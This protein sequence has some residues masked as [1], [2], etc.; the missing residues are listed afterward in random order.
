M[1]KN[2]FFMFNQTDTPEVTELRINGVIGSTWWDDVVEQE[3]INK[4]DSV[5]SKK[6]IVK[7]NSMGGEVFAGFSIYNSLRGHKADIE[8]IVEGMA[9]SVAS[10]IAMAGDTIKMSKTAAI[11]IHNPWTSGARGESKD[12]RSRADALDKMKEMAL[13]AYLTKAKI[14]K[15]EISKMMDET[16]YLTADEALEK[17]FITEIIDYGAG[18]V[19]EDGEILNTGIEKFQMSA[20]KDFPK[21]KFLNIKTKEEKQKKQEGEKERMMT[22]EEF[23]R[24]YPDLYNEVI[25]EGITK[26][27]QRLQAIDELP[28]G[29]GSEA[30]VMEAKYKNYL[31]A[32]DAAVAIL[33]H[34]SSIGKEV[35]KDIKEDLKGNETIET[36]KTEVEDKTEE[37]MVDDVVAMMMEGRK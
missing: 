21:E 11:M 33:K 18:V 19:I 15:E 29:K 22:K 12:L 8:V 5:E 36:S 14:S 13:E 37:Q 20:F 10:V 26:E 9:G 30:I 7:V 32:G 17:G 16:V 28:I 31:S 1:T 24:T 35:L 4:L 6:I 2:K 27:R 25:N 23:M 3:F 34:N